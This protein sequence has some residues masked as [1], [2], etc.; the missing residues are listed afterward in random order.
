MN[1]EYSTEEISESENLI[2][3][4]KFFYD[5]STI[6]KAAIPLVKIEERLTGNYENRYGFIDYAAADFADTREA[7]PSLSYEQIAHKILAGWKESSQS[8]KIL[9][10]NSSPL[11]YFRNYNLF[12]LT[13]YFDLKNVSYNRILIR[14]TK[15]SF[16]QSL[17]RYNLF[18]GNYEP[19][20]YYLDIEHVNFISK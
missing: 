5:D 13:P 6:D 10:K 11:V 2:A 1:Y 12:A 17:A 8:N 3:T 7:Y 15:Y 9:F 4:R 20:R 16:E 18:L 14:Q 19:S